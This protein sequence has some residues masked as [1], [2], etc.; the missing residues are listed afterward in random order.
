[1]WFFIAVAII[2]VLVI[3][4]KNTN[5]N[6]KVKDKTIKNKIVNYEEFYNKKDYIFTKTELQFYYQLKELVNEKYTIFSKTRLVDLFEPKKINER[7]TYF[8]KIKAKHIDFIICKKNGQI[9]TYIELDDNSHTRSDRQERDVFVDKLFQDLGCK[10][11][12]FNVAYK[13]DF[14]ELNKYLNPEVEQPIENIIENKNDM[15]DMFV[16]S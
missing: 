9:V 5:V 1:M 15:N 4:I 16:G 7:H 2:Y 10:L 14:T 13:Y 6:K 3:I 12:R 8:N 11:F